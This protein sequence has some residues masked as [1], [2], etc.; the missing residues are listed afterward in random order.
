MAI[1]HMKSALA[2]LHVCVWG[3]Q[4]WVLQV[5]G[6]LGWRCIVS[7]LAK[8][9]RLL[10]NTAKKDEESVVIAL[11]M[12]GSLMAFSQKAFHMVSWA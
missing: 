10:Q 6:V 4:V 3:L 5:S 8:E 11:I 2:A 7:E 12:S 9:L 1:A